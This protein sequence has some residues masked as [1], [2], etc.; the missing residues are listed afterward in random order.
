MT[1]FKF[2]NIPTSTRIIVAMTMGLIIGSFSVTLYSTVNHLADAFVMLLQMTAL[3][4]ISLSLMV[5]IGG[6]S[7]SKAKSA[8]KSTI[9]LVILLIALMLCFILMAPL[10]FPSWQ[11]AEFYSANTVKVSQEFN[12]VELFIPSNPFNAFANAVIPSVVF[13]SVF[14]GVGLIP[15]KNK[16]QTLAVLGNLKQ[17]VSNISHLVMRF[18]PIGVFCIGWRAAAT[19]DASQLDGL[20]IY[21]ASALVLTALL[22]F[23]VFPA[24]LATITPFGYRAIIKASR[25]AMITAFATGSFFVVIPIIVEKTKQLITTQYPDTDNVDKVSDVIVPISYSLPV[26]GKLL[27]LLFVLFAAW[28]S[29]AY[30]SFEDY[31][32]LVVM[33]IP[34]LFGTSTLA[35]QNLLEIFNVSHSMFDFFLVSE[36]LVVGRLSA[37]LSVTFA[38]CL[39]ILVATSMAKA[40]TLKKKSLIKYLIIIPAI[41]VLSFISLK[42]AFSSISYQYEG[43]VKFIERDFLME[44]VKSTHVDNAQNNSA[45]LQPNVG[46]LSRIKQRGFIRVGYYRD[47]LP[48][49]FHN[50]KGKLVGFDIEIMN[51]LALDLNVDIEFVK[52][53][54]NQAQTLLTSG[55][56]DITTGVPVIPDN[57][58]KYTLTMP[59][60]SQSLAIIV[61]DKRREEFTNWDNILQRDDLILGIP[62][63]FYYEK[64]IARTFTHGKA[65]EISTP[66]LFFKPEFSH[67]DAMLF[68]AAAS[69]AWTLLNP[70]YTVVVPKPELAPLFMAFPI[71]KNDHS[72][73]LFMRNWITMKQQSKTLDKL[74][75]YW[76]KGNSNLANKKQ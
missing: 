64:A 60:S 57:M 67:I 24:L 19:L 6:L 33:G 31:V 49:S 20:M 16:R 23:L 34:Q 48:Y 46:V 21:V 27:S 29:G 62:E 70:S 12:I 1:K 51:Q 37:L 13:F 44:S 52:V 42:Y 72:F 5:G 76:I 45:N 22:T 30:I 28:F 65:W 53:F 75:D 56:L 15:I 63:S 40:F 11:T 69:S 25:E 2:S 36:N 54:R 26:G 7:A 4:Y 68:G 38:S 32:Q 35:M 9:I 55:Y 39:P 3:P 17:S 41:S 10:S 61:K 8:L 59:Y 73:E 18:A 66:R 71:N 50:N 47:D 14:I 58:F 43:Y 74:F